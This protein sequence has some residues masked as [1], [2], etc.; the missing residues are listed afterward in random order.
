M[1]LPL[2]YAHGEG[3]EV[4]I[5]T[6]LSP[7]VVRAARVAA[8]VATFIGCSYPTPDESKGSTESHVLGGGHGGRFDPN[9]PA[10]QQTDAWSCSVYT[11]T[12]ML[13]ATGNDASWS[14]VASDMLSTGGVTQA[15]GLSDASG[16]GLAATLRDLASGGPAIGSA[17]YASFDDVAA[18]AG[19]MAV[20]IGGRAW[21]HWSGVRGYDAERDV[22]LLANSA[23]GYEGVGEAIDRGQFERLGAMAMVWMDYG[24]DAFGTTFEPAERPASDPFPALEVRA[25]IAPDV[26]ITQCGPEEDAERVWQTDGSGPDPATF[27][28]PGRYPEKAEQGC[29]APGPDGVRPL[30]FRG[31]PAGELGGAWI[32]ECSGY[33]DGAQHVFR[34]DGEVDGHPAASFL[35]N[36]A[37]PECD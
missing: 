35:Y 4:F 30:V 31:L 2:H 15:N 9:E 20:G 33:G 3:R 8:V 18:K 25:S 5:M 16:A 7:H 23:V 26:F 22:L 29:G 28:A 32:V 10:P 12:W 36:E 37:N 11:A 34:V 27:W 19:R 21:N 24:D 14:S 6:N 1:A 17:G 13:R